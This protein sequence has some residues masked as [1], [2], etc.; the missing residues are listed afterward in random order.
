MSAGGLGG[1]E[2]GAEVH[3]GEALVVIAPAP[4][5]AAALVR[6][7][8]HVREVPRRRRLRRVLDSTL[9]FFSMY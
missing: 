2:H 5:P 3:R 7:D 1:V 4:G 8:E 9:I 6:L